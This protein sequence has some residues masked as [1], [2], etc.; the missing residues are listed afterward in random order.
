MAVA[1]QIVAMVAWNGGGGG[2]TS[3]FYSSKV[4]PRMERGGLGAGFDLTEP[5]GGRKASASSFGRHRR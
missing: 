1:T 4:A 5:G 2:V 3:G